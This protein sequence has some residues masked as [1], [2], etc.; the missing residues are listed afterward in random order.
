[1]P[2]LVWV[3]FELYKLG[4]NCVV[5]SCS[6][7]LN[8]AFG[9]APAPVSEIAESV[10]N[11]ALSVQSSV[12]TGLSAARRVCIFSLHVVLSVLIGSSLWL[13]PVWG[14]PLKVP[15]YFVPGPNGTESISQVDLSIANW[16]DSL[17]RD[18]VVD[19]EFELTIS[20][21][22]Y[23]AMMFNAAREGRLDT[24]GAVLV[25]FELAGLSE[26]R[27]LVFPPYSEMALACRE[28]LWLIPQTIGLV[29]DEHSMRLPLRED[30]PAKQLIMAAARSG[31][32]FKLIPG[33]SV[34]RAEVRFVQR[35]PGALAKLS[36]CFGGFVT[37][38]ST[39]AYL[40]FFRHGSSAPAPHVQ[41]NGGNIKHG[42]RRPVP[43]LEFVEVQMLAKALS[44]DRNS[45]CT[46]L[47]LAAFE[48]EDRKANGGALRGKVP[49]DQLKP[50]CFRCLKEWEG[51]GEPADLERIVGQTQCLEPGDGGILGVDGD[52]QYRLWLAASSVSMLSSR[53]EMADYDAWLRNHNGSKG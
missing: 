21:Y 40:L 11:A 16:A 1:M 30:V 2:G 50:V 42:M 41:S 34:R 25:S 15:L 5:G 13:I 6:Y 46:P 39:L 32:R 37:M 48:A 14:Y 9:G 19:V 23:R 20:N 24:A 3:P 44:A 43:Q 51:F 52:L 47:T 49:V 17:S 33:L 4:L 10:N 36:N 38:A 27:S 35:P 22:A 26:T 53:R 45:S 28:W 31:A 29:H 7:V 8:G 18:Y 12:S